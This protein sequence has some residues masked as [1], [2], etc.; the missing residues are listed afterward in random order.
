MAPNKVNPFRP[1]EESLIIELKEVHHLSW[2]EIGVAFAKRFPKRSTGSLQV[3]YARKLHKRYNRAQSSDDDHDEI[4]ADEDDASFTPTKP[5]ILPIASSVTPRTSSTRKST[6]A[7]SASS[8]PTKVQKS[9][10]VVTAKAATRSLLP[11]KVKQ[12]QKSYELTNTDDEAGIVDQPDE[13][14][15]TPDPENL[16]HLNSSPPYRPISTEAQPK[17]PKQR[18][19]PVQ[20]QT[21]AELETAQAGVPADGYVDIFSPKRARALPDSTNLMPRTPSSK[22]ATTEQA[23]VSL[24]AEDESIKME[25]A[26]NVRN[27]SARMSPEERVA[28]IRK[29]NRKHITPSQFQPHPC[30]Y[31]DR[32]CLRQSRKYPLSLPR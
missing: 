31:D 1:E 26:R 32:L 14:N 12:V 5:K 13:D 8:S 29:K 16:S 28:K 15:I 27:I 17:R 2:K 21:D 18:M 22:K 9:P 24:G 3:H 30:S 11:R 6:V 10:S 25:R 19:R 23:H 20:D 7:P 4:Q